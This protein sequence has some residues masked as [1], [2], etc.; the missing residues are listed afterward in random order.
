[1]FLIPFFV[2]HTFKTEI[3][4]PGLTKLAIL[5]TG[6]FLSTISKD[7]SQKRF[8]S[9]FYFHKDYSIP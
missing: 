7:S 3:G 6:V 1:M 5:I 8:P 2:I 4:S 9:D